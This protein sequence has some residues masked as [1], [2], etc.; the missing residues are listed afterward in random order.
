ML[1]IA[2][3]YALHIRVA[4]PLKRIHDIVAIRLCGFGRAC[5]QCAS[6]SRQN[7]THSQYLH[8]IK[9]S[10]TRACY[11]ILLVYRRK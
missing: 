4:I 2:G 9:H 8:F 5:F 7:N 6:K 10:E 1:A 11:G 3:P